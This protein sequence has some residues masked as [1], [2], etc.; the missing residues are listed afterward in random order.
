[1]TT[2]TIPVIPEDIYLRVR[3]QRHNTNCSIMLVSTR[4]Q[5]WDCI[6]SFES[7]AEH[8]NEADWVEKFNLL[9][10]GL[11]TDDEI[12]RAVNANENKESFRYDRILKS[13]C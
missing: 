11:D 1:M 3:C 9:Y 6:K 13:M 7:T 8:Y 12:Q 5:V 4:G 2:Y 10:R